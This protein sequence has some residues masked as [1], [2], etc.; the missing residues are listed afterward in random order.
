[1]TDEEKK[2]SLAKFEESFYKRRLINATYYRDVRNLLKEKTKV[3]EKEA[4][5]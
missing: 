1:L 2:N 4:E 3:K 5:A